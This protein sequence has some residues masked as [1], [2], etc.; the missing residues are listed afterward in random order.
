MRT[1]LFQ[2][3][4]VH[5]ERLQSGWA[6]WRAGKQ[7][8]R[9]RRRAVVRSRPGEQLS[10]RVQPCPTSSD[11]VR[12]QR[13]TIAWFGWRGE[14]GRD[15]AAG[16]NMPSLPR[17][18]R[19]RRSA[20]RRGGSHAHKFRRNRAVMSLN[21]IYSGDVGEAP[22]LRAVSRFSV[23]RGAAPAGRGRRRG[24][25]PALRPDRRASGLSSPS[26]VPL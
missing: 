13:R 14:S 1:L 19:L 18:V 25:V 16:R 12:S 23:S 9:R 6:A 24:K 11:L 22:R 21:C 3:Q 8:G 10:N 2:S 5:P 20:D 26:G 15:R 4:K 17:A 7:T